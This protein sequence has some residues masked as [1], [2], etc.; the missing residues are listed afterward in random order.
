MIKDAKDYGQL[1]VRMRA[2][3]TEL[4]T[5]GR[6]NVLANATNIDNLRQMLDVTVYKDIV[7]EE[8]C[9]AY[10]NL[11]NIDRNLIQHYVDQ[12][13]FYKKLVPKK[14][15]S[16]VE[17]HSK[18][19]FYNNLKII[20]T[21]LHGTQ[22]TVEAKQ[23]L[24]TLT[25]EENEQIQR[26]LEAKTVPQFVEMVQEE[27]L[28]EKLDDALPEYRF[29][30]LI[31]PLTNAIDQYFYNNLCQEIEELTGRD[32]ETIKDI[33]GTEIDLQNIET[34]LRLKTFE[35]PEKIVKKWLIT[36]SCHLSQR[37]FE[38]LLQIDDIERGIRYVKQHTPYRELADRLLLNIQ[39]EQ[40]SL[41]N[42]DR[43]GDQ[44]I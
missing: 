39:E 44:I 1:N 37:F 12:Y 25:E 30:D 18:I 7:C 23:M 8:M 28:K 3:R 5:A 38:K 13:N 31:Y 17:T 40:P 34:I 9:E 24:I 26:L 10:P 42:F 4:L 19:Y 35:I 22:N 11:I 29:L 15:E 16:F 33:F 14:A 41:H 6:Y 27:A 32:K 43:Y 20:L 21:A 36:K 2:K